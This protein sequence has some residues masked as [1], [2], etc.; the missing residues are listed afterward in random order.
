MCKHLSIKP[1]IPM[2]LLATSQVTLAYHTRPFSNSFESVLLCVSLLTYVKFSEKATNKLAF[3]LGMVFSL[4]IFTRITFPLYALPIGI[5]LIYQAYKQSDNINQFTAFI[6][7]L[8]FGFVS[9]SALN[10]IVDSV[11]YGTLSFTVNG[12]SFK[13]VSHVF[14]TLF[15]PTSLASVRS[16]GDIVITPINNFLYNS[17][18]ENLAQHGL[19]PRFTHFAVNFP[20]LFGPLAIFGLLYIPNALSK[21]AKSPNAHVFY[22]LLGVLLSGLVGLSI[23]PHQEARFLCPLLVPLILIYTWRENQYSI[24]VYFWL[25]WIVFNIVTTYIFGVVHQ[26]GV[27]PAVGFLQRQTTG[28]HD[29]HLVSTGDLACTVGETNIETVEY[30]EFSTTTNMIFY[31]TYMPPQ[32]L[33]TTPKESKSHHV[34]VLD[35]SSNLEDAVAEMVNRPGV[36]L[37]HT[38]TT[39]EVDFAK[40]S[41]TEF[42]RTLLVIPGFVPLPKVEGHRYLLMA[43]FGPHLSFDDMDKVMEN[44]SADSSLSC[45]LSHLLRIIIRYTKL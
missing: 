37:R 9:F 44:A 40:S 28:L 36:T 10:I 27:I 7:S 15:N 35:F 21:I 3:R 42:E 1:I 34:R 30:S 25:L 39:M 23:I 2:I 22:V 31:K 41:D 38:K 33:L 5:A 19:H 24:S 26:G 32:H 4:G 45:Y 13:N 20:L 43:T 14:T 17:K 29:C 8:T 18:V 16:Y 6:F 11:F 12:Q